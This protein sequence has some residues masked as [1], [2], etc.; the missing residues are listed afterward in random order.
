MCAFLHF[1][2]VFNPPYVP[3]PDEE[4]LRSGIAQAW[5]GGNRGRVVIDKFLPVVWFNHRV[6]NFLPPFTS[7][8]RWKTPGMSLSCGTQLL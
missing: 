2:Q 1:L 7:Q 5:A 4:V 3:T 6:Q 8:V